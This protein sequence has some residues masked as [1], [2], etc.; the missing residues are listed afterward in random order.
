MKKY[1]ASS[2]APIVLQSLYHV[3]Y[4]EVLHDDL[5]VDLEKHAVTLDNA[6]NITPIRRLLFELSESLEEADENIL[7]EQ[8]KLR[9]SSLVRTKTME[10]TML[11]LLREV[12]RDQLCQLIN[13]SIEATQ[14]VNLFFFSQRSCG[15]Q[16]CSVHQDWY[17]SC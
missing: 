8:L 4:L 11:Q 15:V 13:E 17:E 10:T 6:P 16:T 14:N 2:W 12:P 5:E 7:F 3:G 9:H 1:Q